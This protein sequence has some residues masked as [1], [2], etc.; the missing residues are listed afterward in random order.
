MSD[1]SSAAT[2]GIARKNV[3]VSLA[4]SVRATSR[5]TSA[6]RAA[7]G[8]GIRASRMLCQSVIAAMP[9]A[10]GSASAIRSKNTDQGIKTYKSSAGSAARLPNR[11]RAIASTIAP[12]ISANTAT[13]SRPTT[14]AELPPM[15]NSPSQ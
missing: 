5:P 7:V 3:V 15:K 8:R 14:S 2:T 6:P 10:N 12:L 11:A 9:A 4:S 1:S 13:A